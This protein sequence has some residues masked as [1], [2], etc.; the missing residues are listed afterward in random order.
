MKLILDFSPAWKCGRSY[1]SAASIAHSMRHSGVVGKRMSSA[2]R[3]FDITLV[4]LEVLFQKVYETN[5]NFIYQQLGN[6][7][8]LMHQVDNF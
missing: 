6:L 4:V 5:L 7:K 3:G 1:D 8:R 2:A